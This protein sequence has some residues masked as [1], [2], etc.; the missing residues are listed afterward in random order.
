MKKIILLNFLAIIFFF[1]DVKAQDPYQPPA[2]DSENSWSLILIPDTQ[3]YVKFGRNQPVLDLMTSWISE[4]IDPLNIK[5]VLHMGD[6]VEH[7]GLLNPDGRI[8]NQ[9]G[10]SQ[11]EAVS[12]SLG[13]LDGRVPYIAATGNHDYGVLNVE[14]RKT[15]YNKYFPVDKNFLTQRMLREVALDEDGM[16]TLTNAAYEFTSPE[17]R[18]FLILV[19]E[20]APRNA[21]LEWGI[22]VVNQEKYQDHTVIL[23][24]HSYLNYKNEHIESEGYPITDANYGK[25][26]WEKLVKPSKNIQMVFSG[27]IG[28]PDAKER[29]VGFRTDTN[30]AGQKVHQMTFNAQALGGGWHG[31]GGDGWLRILEFK[32]NNIQVKTFSPLFAI[33]P[34]TRHF[35]WGTDEFKPFSFDLD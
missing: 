14:N 35:A 17:G 4:Q 6:L 12:R 11:W 32:G 23:L 13:K 18:E 30:A 2:L 5:L 16:P 27:H 15:E 7:N 29:H 28:G 1:G 34:T 22:E 25:A 8:G 19:L 20:F 21:N 31:N 9:P 26:V 24:T 10:K 3:N 33:S